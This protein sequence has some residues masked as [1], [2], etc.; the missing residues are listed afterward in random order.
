MLKIDLTTG[1]PRSV[2]DELLG[3]YQLGRA[4]DKGIATANGLQGEYHY[5]CPMDQDVFAFL[6]IDQDALMDVLKKA[7][8]LNEITAYLKPFVDKKSASEIAAWNAEFLKHAPAPDTQAWTY[9]Y[10]T[11][12]AIAPTRTDVTTWADLLDLDE[13]RTV[14]ERALA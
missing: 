1:Y 11:R 12:N 4:V 3:V 6:G 2:R 10:E 7:E 5:N 13:K 8:S 14:P 9:F